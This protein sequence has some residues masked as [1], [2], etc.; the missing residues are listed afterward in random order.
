MAIPQRSH[1]LGCG[2]TNPGSVFGIAHCREKNGQCKDRMY[3]ACFFMCKLANFSGTDASA[4]DLC[5]SFKFY[6]RLITEAP[7]T[8]SPYAIALLDT[9]DKKLSPPVDTLLY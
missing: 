1:P 3:N 2:R 8:L 6:Y 4:S 9:A 5:V 7:F